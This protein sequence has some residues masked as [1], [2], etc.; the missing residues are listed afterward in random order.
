[1]IWVKNL[2]GLIDFLSVVIVHAPDDFPRE[3]FLNDDEQ[4]TLE[5]AFQEIQFGMQFVHEKFKDE[6]LILQLKV[7]LEQSFDCYRNGSD[8]EGAHLLQEFEK[9]L[10]VNNS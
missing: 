7:I 9:L 4:L 8:I 10:L 5:K 1:M 6:H 2:A 3:D